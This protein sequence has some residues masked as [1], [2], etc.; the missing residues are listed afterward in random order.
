MFFQRIAMPAVLVAGLAALPV[1]AAK[2]QY[3]GPPCTPFPLTWP[4]CIV[5]AVVGT[6]AAV[7]TAP[8]RVVAPPP[9]YYAPPPA[10]YYPPPPAYP[11]PA[12]YPAPYPR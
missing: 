9:Y 11:P 5:G 2:A 10:R 8:F 6:T 3:Y 4:F 12:Y 1:S 7:V